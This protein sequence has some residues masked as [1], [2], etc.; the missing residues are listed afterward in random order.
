MEFGSQEFEVGCVE[1]SEAF[2]NWSN[3]NKSGFSKLLSGHG[4]HFR[5]KE[6]WEFKNRVRPEIM[7]TWANV[8]VLEANVKEEE[9]IKE[10][11][12]RTQDAG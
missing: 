7:K 8:L 4:V 6:D 12:E 5:L 11:S 9:E 3:Q 1:P 10:T 2:E